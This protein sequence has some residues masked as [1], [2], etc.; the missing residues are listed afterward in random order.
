MGLCTSCEADRSAPQTPYSLKR[1]HTWEFVAQ[2]GG[3]SK[4]RTSDDESSLNHPH[5]IALYKTIDVFV[6]D[7]ENH[8]VQ[9]YSAGD[10]L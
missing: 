1:E 2:F 5:C 10:R 4:G 6:T 8:R 3:P 9:R 7:Y